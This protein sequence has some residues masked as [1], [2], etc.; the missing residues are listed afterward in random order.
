M[1]FRA[2]MLNLQED[3]VFIPISI[4]LEINMENYR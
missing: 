4:N 3:Q 1:M 2:L